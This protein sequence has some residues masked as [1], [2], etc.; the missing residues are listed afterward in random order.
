[1]SKVWKFAAV[2]GG[3][4]LFFGIAVG[5]WVAPVMPINPDVVPPPKLVSSP[6]A[7]PVGPACRDGLL[8]ARIAE[9]EQQ[10]QGARLELRAAEEQLSATA[11]E[12]DGG[13]DAAT[14]SAL[15]AEARPLLF[16]TNAPAQF[17]PKGFQD[18]VERSIKECSLQMSLSVMD[19]S[20]YP[21]VAWLDST[22]QTID[23]SQC[24]PWRD[25][26]GTMT[27]VVVSDPIVGPD[28]KERKYVGL[29]PV[30]QDKVDRRIAFKR[31]RERTNGMLKSLTGP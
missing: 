17:S 24:S 31:A 19:C 18:V 23:M 9:L 16:P 13:L 20:E 2:S 15:L 3:L 25:A 30:P 28:G 14:R 11:D 21:C 10:L 8:R 5:V 22:A 12:S 1:M 6:V 27:S 29:M 26:F 4:G 7:A